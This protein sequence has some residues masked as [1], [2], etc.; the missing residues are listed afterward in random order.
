MS[1]VAL[2][3]PPGREVEAIAEAQSRVQMLETRAREY[4]DEPETL[5]SINETLNRAR[6]RLERLT[7]PW[8]HP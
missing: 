6:G 1:G 5:D 4:A 3:Y 7:A 2:S 8:R